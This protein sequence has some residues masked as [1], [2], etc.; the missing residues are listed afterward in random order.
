M[1]MKDRDDEGKDKSVTLKVAEP[2]QRDAGRGIAKIDEETVRKLEV[3]R[4]QVR[5]IK[6][7]SRDTDIDCAG[8]PDYS[9]R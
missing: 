3:G 1:V 7:K 6:G 4:G 9:N 5:K 8:Y 2:Y